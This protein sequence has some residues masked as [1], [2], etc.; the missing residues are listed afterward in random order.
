MAQ[1]IKDYADKLLGE[2]Y[3]NTDGESHNN[4][5]NQSVEQVVETPDNETIPF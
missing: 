3:I 4:I 1:E 2:K 5:V